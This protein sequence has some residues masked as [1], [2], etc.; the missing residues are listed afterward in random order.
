MRRWLKR[1]AVSTLGLGALLAILIGA[2]YWF[3]GTP[4]FA[5]LIA[6][7]IA[8]YLGD[9]LDRKVTIGS[10]AIH[11]GTPHHV[12]VRD[13]RIG[14]HAGGVAPNFATI[15]E[16]DIAVRIQSVW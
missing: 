13:V 11:R 1:A 12:I 5:R 7:R 3:V 16:I 4:R 15:G 9:Q 14:N 8:K 2:G 10:I 6:P